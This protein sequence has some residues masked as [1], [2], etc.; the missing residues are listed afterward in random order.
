VLIKMKEIEPF[1]LENVNNQQAGLFFHQ[2]TGNET[3]D[4]T[5]NT[6]PKSI[7][8]YSLDYNYPAYSSA[9]GILLSISIDRFMSICQTATD[10]KQVIDP[11]SLGQVRFE[12]GGNLND[13]KLTYIP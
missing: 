6:T 13:T 2:L 5:G 3:L 9:R 4:Y 8:I 10:M 1:N 7:L 11:H 12:F